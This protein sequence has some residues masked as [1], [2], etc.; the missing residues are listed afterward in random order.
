MIAELL[1]QPF[2]SH[3]VLWRG[4][5]G[6]PVI[7]IQMAPPSVLAGT[8]MALSGLSRTGELT[9]LFSLGFGKSRILTTLG[10]SVLMIC[11]G[12]MLFQDRIAPIFAKKRTAYYWHEMKKRPDFFLDV[13]R[14]KVW[15][16]SKNLIFNLRSFDSRSETINGMSVYTLDERFQLVQLVAARKAV[17]SKGG[18]QLRDGTVTVFE[19]GNAFPLSQHFDTKELLISETPK[20]F[21]EIEKEV[22][23]LRLRELWSYIA[24]MREAGTNTRSF[25]VKFHSRIAICFMP[26]IMCW[27]GVPFS[28]SSRRSGGLA[29]DLGLALGATFFYWLFYSISLSLG[30]N[31]AL[32]PLLA[33]WLPSLIFFAL[34]MVLVFRKSA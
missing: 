13:K 2:P 28:M 32:H 23:T 17:H 34:A 33:A 27:M 7:L 15:Y 25:E 9:A 31:G 14:D 26:L 1:E 4:A 19:S 16:R 8:V 11:S 29:R 6:L 30:T 3:Q 20:D 21:Q 22:D 5:L 10:A 12:L 24:R 18:W